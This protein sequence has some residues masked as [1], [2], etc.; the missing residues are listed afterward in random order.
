MMPST[1]SH[2]AAFIVPPWKKKKE[3]YFGFGGC[4]RVKGEQRC[5]SGWVGVGGWVAI[6]GLVSVIQYELVRICRWDV[7]WDTT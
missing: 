4:A 2:V 3:C 1:D 7:T 5:A 6:G